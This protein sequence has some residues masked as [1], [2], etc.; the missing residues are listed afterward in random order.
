M[1]QIIFLK[2]RKKEY[3]HIYEACESTCQ[4]CSAKDKVENDKEDSVVE[5]S[6]LFMKEDLKKN[7]IMRDKENIKIASPQYER[8]LWKGHW[9]Q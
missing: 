6:D 2:S 9:S 8:E 1:Q 7:K 3:N 4:K 5:G